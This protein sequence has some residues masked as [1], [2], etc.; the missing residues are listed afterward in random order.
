MT[1]LPMHGAHT[2]SWR[3]LGAVA[4]RSLLIGAVSGVVGGGLLFFVFGFIG[5]AGAPISSR[6]ANGWRALLDPGLVKG[7]GVGAGV[8]LGLIALIVIWT[9]LAR[10]FEPGSARPWLAALAGVIVPLFNLEWLRSSSG[11]D[12]AGIVT[13]LGIA[14]LVGV[15]VW[16]VAPWV[17]RDWRV[18]VGAGR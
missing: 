18:R 10:S 12:W 3:R 6:A 15:V 11:W 2:F 16:M 17:L 9:G 1:R 8:A 4:A 14:L 5:F 13:V 7:L